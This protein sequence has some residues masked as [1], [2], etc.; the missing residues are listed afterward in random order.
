[1][2]WEQC[3]EQILIMFNHFATPVSSSSKIFC[4]LLV[5]ASSLPFSQGSTYNKDFVD[6]RRFDPRG[7]R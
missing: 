6:L 5:K 7:E 1:M 4:A 3:R 2:S